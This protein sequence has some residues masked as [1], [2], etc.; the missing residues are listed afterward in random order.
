MRIAPYRRSCLSVSLYVRGSLLSVAHY[1]K[2][3]LRYEPFFNK[4]VGKS[5]FVRVGGLI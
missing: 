1:P 2:A 3:L 5:L 4:L